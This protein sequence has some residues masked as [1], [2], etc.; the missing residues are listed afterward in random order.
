MFKIVALALV[1]CTMPALASANG[2]VLASWN[3]Q[4]LTVPGEKVFA[5]QKPNELRTAADMADLRSVSDALAADVIVLEEISSPKALAQVFPVSDWDICLS[6]QYTADEDGLAPYYAA[7]KLAAIKP[8]CYSAGD[9][10][11]P[12]PP[13]GQL[14]NQYVGVAVR[15]AAGVTLVSVKDVPD[16]SVPSDEKSDSG[17]VVRNVRWGLEAVIEKG[18]RALG[19][20]GVHLKTGCFVGGLFERWW[21]APPAQWHHDDQPDAPCMTLA[22]QMR[23][24]RAWIASVGG[25]AT[26]FVIVGDFNRRIDV[27]IT[28][29]D[30]PDLLPVLDGRAT[31]SPADDVTLERVPEGASSVHTCWPEDDGSAYANSIDYMLFGPGARPAA[32]QS[33]YKKLRF[34]D[35]AAIGG[36]SLS[37]ATNDWRLS[38]HCPIRVTVE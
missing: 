12:D 21:G 33:N 30:K 5:D 4:T 9:A 25:Q 11:L 14:R 3:I 10:N 23:P 13:P 29:P 31:G 19:I 18:G 32:W 28:D 16:L 27:E 22:R 38:D 37:K 1:V 7:D 24:L 15:R 17:T 20:L 8:L 6:G 26:P 35:I 36:T 2:F 34:V